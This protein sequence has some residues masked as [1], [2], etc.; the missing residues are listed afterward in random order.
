MKILICTGIYPPEIGGPAQYAKN[1]SEF[2]QK[3]G[4]RV[5]VKVFSRFNF[6]PTG[7]RHLVYFFNIL[8]NRHQ[9]VSEFIRTIRPLSSWIIM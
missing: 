6:L 2:W 4:H 7:L 3:E 9:L 1:L 8:H 5:N